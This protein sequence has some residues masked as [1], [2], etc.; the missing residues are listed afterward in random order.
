MLLVNLFHHIIKIIEA[1]K[2]AGYFH[3]V[4]VNFNWID[5]SELTEVNN[6]EAYII[7]SD[8]FIN[9]DSDNILVNFINKLTKNNV[10]T[11][12]LGNAFY[13]Y[14]KTLSNIN[15][16]ILSRDNK[17]IGE[18]SLNNNELSER[19]NLNYKLNNKYSNL[20]DDL[21]IKKEVYNDEVLGI[22]LNE[23]K[24]FKAL[25]Y[26]PEFKSRP[27]RPREVFKELIKSIK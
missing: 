26:L 3:H 16:L 13:L 1:V 24:Y 14:F 11:L 15:D 8:S 19:F 6:K 7:T 5:V 25:S 18:L 2:H 10:S 23:Y 4:K 9:N 20:L 17:L 12:L 21:N 22:T 27:L